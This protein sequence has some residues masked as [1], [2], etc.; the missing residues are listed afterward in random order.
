MRYNQSQVDISNRK[1][2]ENDYSRT[3]LRKINLRIGS[4]RGLRSFSIEFNYPLAAISGK[5]GSGKSTIL[6]IAACGYHNTAGGYCLPGRKQSYY[7]FFD[8]FI[9]SKDEFPIE[10]VYIDYLFMH[11][12]WRSEK[13]EDKVG[14]KWQTRFKNHGG[15]W[16]NYDSRVRRPVLYFG[17]SRVTPHSEKSTSKSYKSRFKTAEKKG[18]EERVYQDVA[19]VLGLKYTDFEYGFHVGYRL[20]FVKKGDVQYSG[21]NMG[22]GENALFDLFWHIHESPTGTLVL[23]DEIE[24]GLHESAQKN[25]ILKLKEVALEKKMQFIFTTHSSHILKHLPPDARYFIEPGS[26]TKIHQGISHQYAKGLLGEECSNELAIYV[27]DV[28]AATIISS[29]LR[30]TIR[31]RIKIIPIGSA[32]AVMNQAAA[33][34]KNPHQESIFILDGDQK[35]KKKIHYSNFKSRMERSQNEKEEEDKQWIESRLHFLPSDTWPEKWALEKISTREGIR[36]IA[37][38][39]KSET[40]QVES[41]LSNASLSKKHG[42]I[43]TLANQL[44]I[45]QRYLENSIFIFICNQNADEFFEITN[46]I[47]RMLN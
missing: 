8:F 42:E 34:R 20:P 2:F 45:D 19:F 12:N 39:T 37:D 21:F 6:A 1:W 10:G 9:V 17:I 4:V 29:L 22:T 5:N 47:E 28:L 38:I 7:T 25:L 3:T 30:T 44:L 15:K 11:N 27:E 33:E 32:A 31:S 26:R 13:S 14:K 41:A 46:T 35:S 16:N 18:I 36:H 40:D 43:A 23:I 24:L